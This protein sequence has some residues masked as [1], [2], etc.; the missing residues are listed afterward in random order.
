M[1]ESAPSVVVVLGSAT[2]PGRLHR[3]IDLELERLDTRREVRTTLIDLATVQIALADGRPADTLG[4]DTE[5][6]VSSLTS[7][8]VVVLATPVY[9]GSLTGALKNLLDQ[10]PVAALR[11]KPVAIVAMGASPHHYLGADR[12]LRDILSFFGALV[13]PTAV[14]LQS[15]DF[16]EGEPQAQALANLDAV[17]DTALALYDGLAGKNLGP[18]PLAAGH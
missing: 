1:T 9:R 11:D 8:D 4:D 6:T 5:S 16:V 3:A 7:A 10:T 14:Y 12:H 2:P 13:C 18:A 15:S 17:V